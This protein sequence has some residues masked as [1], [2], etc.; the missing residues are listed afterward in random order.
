MARFAP[1]AL[2][3]AVM[4][5][6]IAF[7][8]PSVKADGKVFLSIATDTSSGSTMPRQRAIIAFKDGEQRLAI[9]TAFTGAGEE[10]AWLVPLPSEPEILPATKGMF[11]T[12]AM[13]TA[14]RVTHQGPPFELTIAGLLIFLSI[15]IALLATTKR[16]VALI[17]VLLPTGRS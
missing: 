16:L 3:L 9:D 6:C 11:D 1:I 2:M 13:V 5:M 17:G 4:F 12:A 7:A 10:F 14:P 15:T 8:T